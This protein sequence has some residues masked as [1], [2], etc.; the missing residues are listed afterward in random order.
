MSGS[1]AGTCHWSEADQQVTRP[2]YANC[3]TSFPHVLFHQHHHGTCHCGQ[4]DQQVIAYVIPLSCPCHKTLHF[5]CTATCHWSQANQQVSTHLI[6][7]F[8]CHKT[9]PCQS[10]VISLSYHNRQIQLQFFTGYPPPRPSQYLQRE[11]TSFTPGC[12]V[13]GEKTC[14][15]TP[16]FLGTR[17]T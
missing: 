16:H 3:P 4:A 6:L 9:V 17:S 11:L 14:K 1:S 7:Q 2:P 15:S 8:P 5:T 12:Q 10:P 13:G